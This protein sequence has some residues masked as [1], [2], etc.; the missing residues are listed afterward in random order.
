[1]SSVV[2]RLW[3]IFITWTTAPP[4][5]P[6]VMHFHFFVTP[7][8]HFTFHFTSYCCA[9]S[10]MR[11]AGTRFSPWKPITAPHIP[12]LASHSVPIRSADISPSSAPSHYSDAPLPTYLRPPRR[13][14]QHIFL[15]PP[16]LNPLAQHTSFTKPRQYL[17][18]V[19]PSPTHRL[20]PPDSSL[21]TLSAPLWREDLAGS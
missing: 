20:Q 16:T 13:L 1:M 15:S 6:S 3:E 11:R 8:I 2:I 18:S 17:I 12:P 7:F 9:I 4:P 5:A 14:P 19:C 21:G 10:K